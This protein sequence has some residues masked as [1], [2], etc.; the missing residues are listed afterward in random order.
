MNEIQ[1]DILE[2]KILLIQLEVNQ[3]RKLIEK[4][5]VTKK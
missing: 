3:L 4:I 2:R 1:K 5:E